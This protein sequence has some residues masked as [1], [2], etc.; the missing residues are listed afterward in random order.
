[1]NKKIITRIVFPI[2]IFVLVI[3]FVFLII[4][5]VRLFQLYQ[6]DGVVSVTSSYFSN[7]F[8]IILNIFI[9]ILMVFTYIF[10]V[11]GNINIKSK[12]AKIFFCLTLIFICLYF[13]YQLT[14]Y[15]AQIQAYNI[16]IKNFE[17]LYEGA[18]NNEQSLFYSKILT[19]YKN[20]KISLILIIIS[21]SL[22]FISII[23]TLLCLFIYLLKKYHLTL[24]V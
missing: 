18:V 16:S 6:C 4:N 11:K 12:L 21:Y 20:T 22:S 8:S 15:I 9:I 10:F 14:N 17:I 1:M 19:C 23:I 13:A 24:P 3:N 2:T 5:K 7:I